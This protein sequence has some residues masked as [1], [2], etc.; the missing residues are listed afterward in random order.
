[1]VMHVALPMRPGM[2]ALVAEWDSEVGNWIQWART[3]GFD[4]YWYFRD[5][6]FDA[7]LPEPGDRT[8]EIGCG[9]GRVARDLTARGHSVVAFD[10]ADQL[11]RAA[12]DADT[13]GRYAVADGSAIPFPDDSFDIV[14]AY[15]VL[16]V[17]GDLPG[18]V[19]EASRVL[20]AGGVLCVCLIHPV[21]DLGRFAGDGDEARFVLRERYF[22]VR[23]IEE[24]EEH[25]GITMTFT[26]WTYPLEEYARAFEA[27]GLRIEIIREPRP[28]Q[29]PDRYDKWLDVPLFLA[30][31]AVKA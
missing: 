21:T 24:T 22:D 13:T 17:V 31:R 27:A 19:R 25:E 30:L 1:M 12:A 7:I 28:A 23:R 3:P 16:Q 26:G 14:V 20:R 6:V 5:A 11:V 9:E 4:A 29:H 18:T 8:L 10:P 15:N 2:M